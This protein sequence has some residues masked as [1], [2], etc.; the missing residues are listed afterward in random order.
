MNGVPPKI[1]GVERQKGRPIPR[2][3][4]VILLLLALSPIGFWVLWTAG[5]FWN[6]HRA[7]AGF[8]RA[9]KTIDPELL[10]EWEQKMVAKYPFTNQDDIARGDLPIPQTEIPDQLIKLYSYATPQAV[11]FR[12]DNETSPCVGVNWGGGFLGWGFRIGRT[13]A[14]VNNY[15]GYWT[16]G[17]DYY[18]N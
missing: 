1:V 17:V 15:F 16:N 4:F 18:R 11:I 9:K 10:L 12:D 13:N 6:V 7:D 14:L 3:V 5:A 2:Y 8:K